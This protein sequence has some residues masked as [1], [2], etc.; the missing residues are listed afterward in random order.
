MT[1]IICPHCG[2]IYTEGDVSMMPGVLT[3][4]DHFEEEC[5]ECGK[6][7]TITLTLN[8]TYVVEKKEV[9]S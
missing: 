6:I 9:P 5:V 4:D 1:T 3:L 2:Y 7:F 8:A